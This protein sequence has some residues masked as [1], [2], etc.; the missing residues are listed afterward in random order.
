MKEKKKLTK[1]QIALI[2][3]LLLGLITVVSIPFTIAQIARGRRA[4]TDLTGPLVGYKKPGS[5]P[6]PPPPPPN[7]VGQPKQGR[8]L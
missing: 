5:K 1:P 3:V 8:K 6:V 2:V 4:D 7:I